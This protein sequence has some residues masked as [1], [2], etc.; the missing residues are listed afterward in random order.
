MAE[1]KHTFTSGRMNKDLDDRLV[2]NG[3]YIDALNIQISSSEGSDVGSIENTLGNELLSDLNLTGAKTLGS[4]S[5][6]KNNKIYWLTTSDILDAIYEYDEKT[7]EVKPILLDEKTTSVRTIKNMSLYSNTEGELSFNYKELEFNSILGKPLLKA[8]S[9]NTQTYGLV[10]SNVDI[11]VEELNLKIS[12]PKNT[13]VLN[14]NNESIEFKNIPYNGK[15]YGNIEVKFTYSESGFLNFSKNNLIT[16]INIIDGLLFWTDGINQPR[17]INISEFKNYRHIDNQTQISYKYKDSEG[18]TKIDYRPILEDDI[19]VIK[20]SPLRAPKI[21]LFDTNFIGNTTVTVNVNFSNKIVGDEVTISDFGDLPN[22]D[23]GQSVRFV[24]EDADLSLECRVKTIDN[25]GNKITVTISNIDSDDIIGQ[26]YLFTVNLIEEDPI[27]ELAFVRFAYRWKYKN[28]EYSV[29]SPFTQPAFYPNFKVNDNEFKYDGKEAYNYGMINQV[30]KILLEDFDL[31]SDEVEDI[32]IIFKETRNNNIYILISK[33]RIEFDNSF[34]IKKEQIKSLVANDQLLR[35]WDNVPRKAKAQEVTANRVMYGN[36]TQSYDVYNNPSFNVKLNTLQND[37]KTS[38]KS[39]RSYQL[40]VVYSDEYNRQTPVFSDETGVLNVPKSKAQTQNK[41]SASITSSP[42][43]WAT[44]YRYFIKE[45]SG[46]YYNLAADRFYNDVENG[47]MY[48]SFPSSERNKVTEDN[49]LLLKKSHGDN[50]AVTSDDNRYKIIDISAEPPEF[51]TARKRVVRSLGNIVFTDDY[52]GS[53]GGVTITNK[54]DASNAAP[55]KDRAEIQIKQAN[56]SSDGVELNETKEIRP[57]RFISFEYLGKESKPYEVKRLLQ[58]PAGSNEIKIIFQE[59][60]GDDVEIIYNKTTGNLGDPS[61]NAGVAMNILEEYTAAG[62]KEFDGRFFIKLKSNSTLVN[63]IITQEIGGKSYLVKFDFNMIGIYSKY[64][65]NGTGR[66]GANTWKNVNRGKDSASDNPRNDFLIGKGGTAVPGSSYE[67]GKRHEAGGI[68]YNITVEAST[69][70]R[71]SEVDKLAKL[72]KVGNFVRFV[73]P[74]GTPHHDKIYEIG[75]TLVSAYATKHGGNLATKRRSYTELHFR[76]VDEDGEFQPLVKD[77]VKRGDDTW[78]NEPRMEI[79]EERVEENLVVKEPSIF[80]TEPLESKTELNIYYEASDILPIDQHASEYKLNWYNCI[81]FGNGVESNRIRDDF[82]AIFIDNGVKASTVLD[83]PYREEQKF[84]SLIWSG[85]INSRSGVNRSNEFNMANPIT[86]DF[87]PSYGSV[88]KLHAWDDSMVVICEDKTLRVLANKSALYNANGSSNLIS[89]SRVIGDPIEYNGDYGISTNPESFA[90]HGFRCYFAD[91]SR[92][93]V[94]RL[95][96]DGISPISSHYMNSFF[97]QRL[98]SAETF[99]GSYDARKKLYNISFDGLDTVCFSEDVSGWVTRASFIPENA[100][101]LNNIYYT[102]LNGELWRHDSENVFRNNFYGTQYNSQVEF[103][104]NDDPSVI[105]KYRTLG[106]EGTSSWVAKEIK[107]DQVKGKETTFEPKENKYF[108]NITQENKNINTLDQKNFSTQGIGR[109][110]RKPNELDYDVTVGAQDLDDFNVKINDGTSWSSNIIQNIEIKQDGSIDDIQI[111]VFPNDGY[112]IEKTQFTTPSDLITVENSDPNVVVKVKGEYL[113][114]LNPS[115]GQTVYITLSGK[116]VLRPIKVSGNYTIEG[117]FISDTV[118]NGSY[119]ITEDPKTVQIINTRIIKPNDGYYINVEDVTVNNNLISIS[120]D[121]RGKGYIHVVESLVVPND[122]TINLD[123]TIKVTANEIIIPDKVIFTKKL[124]VDPISNDG[125]TRTITLS[126]EAEAEFELIFKEGSSVIKKI[127]GSIPPSSLKYSCDLIFPAGD[128]AQTYTVELKTKSGSVFSDTFGDETI[129]LNRPLRTI[130]DII[131][132]VNLGNKITT[133]QSSTNKPLIV[134]GYSEDEANIDFTFSYT[135]DGTGYSLSKVPVMADIIRNSNETETNITFNTF[136]LT[137]ATND[138]LLIKGKLTSNNFIQNENFELDIDSILDKNVT[139]TFA[140]SNTIAGGAATSNYT[141]AGHNGATI[142]YTLTAKAGKT[143]TGISNYYFTL[144]AAAGYKSKTTFTNLIPFKIYDASNNDVTSTFANNDKVSF[145]AISP[146]T[147]GFRNKPFTAPT[148]NQTY[149][150]RPLEEI[151]TAKVGVEIR[152]HIRFATKLKA[153]GF[154]YINGS[155]GAGYIN[156]YQSHVGG[157]TFEMSNTNQ[158]ALH[159]IEKFARAEGITQKNSSPSGQPNFISGYASQNTTSSTFSDRTTG[160]YYILDGSNSNKLLQHV[161]TLPNKLFY[162][163]DTDNTS[164]SKYN[165]TN[166]GSYFTKA[167]AGTYTDIFGD[168]KT[169]TDTFEISS[170]GKTLTINMI[171][172]FNDTDVGNTYYKP[173]LTLTVKNDYPGAFNKFL[174]KKGDYSYKNDPCSLIHDDAIKFEEALC[175]DDTINKGSFVYQRTP[176]GDLLYV[177]H[178]NPTYVKDN[179]NILYGNHSEISNGG[180]NSVPTGHYSFIQGEM[181]VFFEETNC[182]LTP[183]N[184]NPKIT[185][186]T[187]QNWIKS[188]PSNKGGVIYNKTVTFKNTSYKNK[189][190]TL[191]GTYADI[192]YANYANVQNNKNRNGT[193]YLLN[194][195]TTQYP[196]GVPAQVAIESCETHEWEVVDP[197]NNTWQAKIQFDKNGYATVNFGIQQ[198]NNI[199]VNGLALF[200]DQLVDKNGRTLQEAESLSQND[201]I[202]WWDQC[203]ILFSTITH[204]PE[205]V[206]LADYSIKPPDF[207]FK[208][209]YQ[210]YKDY[211]ENSNYPTLFTVNIG[212]NRATVEAAKSTMWENPYEGDMPLPPKNQ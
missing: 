145:A 181:P 56:G 59:P 176:D 43:A 195:T 96:K 31:G 82:N 177:G 130:N 117:F 182:S 170:D 194:V 149:T 158:R 33:K 1:L 129:T 109:S 2:P 70:R 161:L 101:Y 201:R 205:P 151:F 199:S 39:N 61:T 64:D 37:R 169:I 113:E 164:S 76:F 150:I 89:D 198:Y 162:W 40:G 153:S 72:A 66:S 93:V 80:E 54:D 146:V 47:F 24:T 127:D 134:S 77:V 12:V 14:N 52:K 73:N 50:T 57:G 36:Y 34:T 51:I 108:A 105:K 116:T 138:T 115:D 22:W 143:F 131:F 112:I 55:L 106:Y 191:K 100:V 95:S 187:I 209:T 135:L 104:I 172:N 202:N 88:Q 178:Y 211:P 25:I 41:I 45:T 74:D 67:T 128:T 11:S 30:R 136:T 118:G 141:I 114:S 97:R 148:S 197:V 212:D 99:Y 124:S 98:F 13:T 142:P 160:M 200:S 26:S 203:G 63:S 165:I 125:E 147:V 206:Y 91:K 157:A 111:I 21:T 185:V 174:I 9:E 4:V 179:P 107:T 123:Y 18:T 79:L 193:N 29:F 173:E 78:K 175:V 132:T 46:E 204:Q 38:V 154:T 102:Y 90:S 168:Q 159:N 166:L 188:T 23:E 35:Q 210:K 44:H 5:D 139:I 137:T 84:N 10:Y 167:T 183:F 155:T 133:A 42:P 69:R 49:Y 28:G 184:E 207:V 62:D 192:R 163:W 86:K 87:L 16:G 27:Y 92:G 189:E 65:A 156:S 144:T 126:G 7:Q 103:I 171:V 20:K 19:S 122:D 17:R 60:F 180:Q 83:E 3:E 190:V 68:E 208:G 8:T 53:G 75:Q 120:K 110:I 81:S 15:H 140:Y 196:K 94:I 121:K 85:I 58:D 48:I 32:E 119:T 152:A 186:D 71:N 6:T